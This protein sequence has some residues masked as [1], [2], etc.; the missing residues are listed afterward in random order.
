MQQY[1]STTIT[2]MMH[3]FRE[4]SDDVQETKQQILY[5][6]LIEFVVSSNK[7]CG[8]HSGRWVS[9]TNIRQAWASQWIWQQKLL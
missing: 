9:P 6:F 3:A 1:K 7:R 5:F 2:E 8:C 4:I